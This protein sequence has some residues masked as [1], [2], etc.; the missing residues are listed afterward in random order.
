MSE[1]TK[2]SFKLDKK[3]I[4][5]AKDAEDGKLPE[6]DGKLFL[7]IFSNVGFRLRGP[8]FGQK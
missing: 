4:K 2:M 6:T 8:T 7:E 1:V 3:L 5:V